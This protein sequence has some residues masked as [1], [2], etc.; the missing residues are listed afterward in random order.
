MT[1]GQLYMDY[2]VFNLLILGI[3][4]CL[5]IAVIIKFAVCC[6]VALSF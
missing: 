2:M 3:H 5:K 6:L 1:M 4:T